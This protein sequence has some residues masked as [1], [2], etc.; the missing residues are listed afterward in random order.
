MPCARCGRFRVLNLRDYWGYLW[1]GARPAGTRLRQWTPDDLVQIQA[2]GCMNM[3]RRSPALQ[4]HSPPH[5]R[6]GKPDETRRRSSS[7]IVASIYT[8][9]DNCSPMRRPSSL[10]VRPLRLRESSVPC[11]AREL[12]QVVMANPV[13]TPPAF[14]AFRG[15]DPRAARRTASDRGRARGGL[16]CLD[17]DIATE[18][19]AASGSMACHCQWL[20][21]S[22]FEDVSTS[23][24]GSESL[25]V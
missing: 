14:D 4:I 23:A 2:A 5:F 25:R 12:C 18:W 8:A 16:S 24:R 10:A 19:Q 3:K 17:R 15:P 20:G 6:E 11:Y 22:E 21:V 7:H 13:G 9:S 1:G